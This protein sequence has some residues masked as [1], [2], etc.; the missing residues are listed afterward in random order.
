MWWAEV[1]VQIGIRQGVGGGL[2]LGVEIFEVRGRHTA[3]SHPQSHQ[4]SSAVS[5]HRS[6]RR[7][8]WTVI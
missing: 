3:K 2:D 8:I 6:W 7:T 1:Q 5:A 4:K